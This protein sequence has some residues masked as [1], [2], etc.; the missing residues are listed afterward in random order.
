MKILFIAP[1]PPPITGQSLASKVFLDELVKSHTVEVINLSKESYKHGVTSFKRI[2]QVVA[3]LKEV[4]HKRENADI[5]YFTISE[6]FA[7]N[8]KDIL[9]YLICFKSLQRM[10]IHLHGGS[11]KRLIFDKNRLLFIINKYFI[12]RLG[13]IIVLGQSHIEIFS[14]IV[15]KKNIHIVPNFAENYLFLK[16]EEIRNKF[17]KTKPLRILFLSNL[18]QGKGYNELLNAYLSLPENFKNSIRIDFAGD[19]ESN[20][21]KSKFLSKICEDKRLQYHG[22]VGCTEKK[23]LF[24]RAHVFCFPSSLLEGQPIVILE[25][26]ASGCVLIAG[27][28]AGMRDIFTADVNGYKFLPESTDSIRSV[29]E[30][31]LDNPE[32]LLPM[33][34]SNRNI[35]GEK[36]R[37]SIYTASLIK[38]IESIGA[39]PDKRYS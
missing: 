29:I 15:G 27:S 21:D 11:I 13:D 4:L 31:V 22:I 34:I 25:A 8:L 32:H 2:I 3:L 23:D 20:A 6:S 16:E 28:Q 5:I 39:G 10:V 7:G 1:L 14:D 35:A 19:F 36:Y 37:T 38:I 18:I 12:R 9:I 33:A 26:Y 24:T 17:E 30:Q